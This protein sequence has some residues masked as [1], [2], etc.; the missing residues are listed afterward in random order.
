[1]TNVDFKDA[2]LTN[3]NFNSTSFNNG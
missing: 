2:I 1:L 3:I